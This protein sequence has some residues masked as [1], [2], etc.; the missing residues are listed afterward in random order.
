[1]KKRSGT[2]QE[3]D[4]PHRDPKGGIL[5]ASPIIKLQYKVILFFFLPLNLGTILIT[6]HLNSLGNSA[7]NLS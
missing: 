1:M 7:K 5:A 4:Q 3:L 2:S 6:D